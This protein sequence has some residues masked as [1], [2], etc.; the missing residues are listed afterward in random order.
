[1]GITGPAGERERAAGD[2]APLLSGLGLTDGL[3]ARTQRVTVR[4]VTVDIELA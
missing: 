1:V 2:A 4:E 3:G